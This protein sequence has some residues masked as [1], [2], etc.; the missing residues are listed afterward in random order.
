MTTY[1]EYKLE[2]GTT[3]LVQID[4]PP[5]GGITKASRDTVGNVIASVNQRFEEAFAGVR[6]SALELRGQ[7]EEMQADEVE[8]TFGLKATGELGNFAIGQV[9]AE[10]NYTVKLKWNNK[11]ATDDKGQKE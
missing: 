4:E 9:G 1:N 7:L 5:V 2:D 8:V 10:A 11:P 6:Q 3:I